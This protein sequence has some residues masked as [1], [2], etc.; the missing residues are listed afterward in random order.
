MSNGVRIDKW[1]WAVRLYKTRTIAADACRR[2]D[3]LVNEQ[4]VKP[5]RDI[6]FGDIVKA[7]TGEI[8]RTVQVTGLIEKRVGPA[9]A[10]DRNRHPRAAAGLTASPED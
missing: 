7:K 3:V 6:H 2:G 9:I 1:L 4:Q 8:V 5:A 10:R